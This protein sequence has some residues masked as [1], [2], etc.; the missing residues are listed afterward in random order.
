MVG[1]SE[2]RMEHASTQE[3]GHGCVAGHFGLVKV[4]LLRKSLTDG[5][6]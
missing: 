5:A 4:K 1:L 6:L 2:V 3:G